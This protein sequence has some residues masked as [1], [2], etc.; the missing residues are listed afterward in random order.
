MEINPSAPA[1]AA[2][3]LQSNADPQTV[4]SVLAA[5]DHVHTVPWRLKAEAERRAATA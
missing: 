3:A 5:I 1:T 2:G 4:F